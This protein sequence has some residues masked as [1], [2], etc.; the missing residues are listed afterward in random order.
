MSVTSLIVRKKFQI[1]RAYNRQK[2]KEY[3]KSMYVYDKSTYA[4]DATYAAAIAVDKIIKEK[5]KFDLF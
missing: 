3:R 1:L 5:G 4:F 2:S